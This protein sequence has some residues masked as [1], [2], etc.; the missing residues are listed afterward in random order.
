MNVDPTVIVASIAALSVVGSAWISTHQNRA[1]KR[2]LGTLNGSGTAMELLES[3]K[4]WIILHESRHGL[5]RR[6]SDH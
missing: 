6:D 4:T 3:I 1:M 2:T 5:D